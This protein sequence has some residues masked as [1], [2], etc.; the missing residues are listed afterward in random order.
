MT[1]DR[2]IFIVGAPRSGTTLVQ[3]ILSAN[4]RAYSLPETH[5]FS[6]VLPTLGVDFD[7]PLTAEQLARAHSLLVDEAELDLPSLPPSRT[8][9]ELLLALFDAFRPDDSRRV[10]AERVVEKTPLHVEHVPLIGA[11]FPDATFIHVVRNPVDVVS[12]WLR[13]PFASTR[14][15]IS[16]AQSWSVAVAA[17]EQAAEWSPTRVRTVRYE[18]LVRDPEAQVSRLCGYV[19]L[20]FEPAM[21]E[22]FGREAARNVGSRESWKA[23]IARGQILNRDQVWRERLSPGQAWLVERATA[24]RR[25]RYGYAARSQAS[26]LSVGQALVG[27]ARVRFDESRGFN[28]VGSSLRHAASP[29]KLLVASR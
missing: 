21:L 12:S 15:V 4:S 28:P 29:V 6:I 7:A 26:P 10:R 9:R 5:F 1:P 19:D 25:R 23:D 24:S 22:E 2:P 3:C 13:V 14:S 20:D 8:A 17:G 11:V 27:E 16:C 18:D